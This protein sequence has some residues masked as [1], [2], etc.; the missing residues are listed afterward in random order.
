[1]DK[2]KISA[3]EWEV[4]NVVW[5]RG[6]LTSREIVDQV[7]ARKGWDS[8]TIRTLVRRLVSKGGLGIQAGSKPQCFE[9]EVSFDEYIQEESRSFLDRGFGGKPE[10]MLLH[11][12]EHTKLTPEDI[13]KFRKILSKKAK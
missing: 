3:A 8:S 11:F 10:A 7:S 12:V 1:M 5:K 9:A 2:V 13:Q 6:S 4:M